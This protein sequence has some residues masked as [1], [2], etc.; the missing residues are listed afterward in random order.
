M[1]QRI[2]KDDPN[3]RIE[4][5]VSFLYPNFMT[6]GWFTAASDD[7]INF[8]NNVAQYYDSIDEMETAPPQKRIIID[9]KIT[10]L[11]GQGN[12]ETTHCF[13]EALR[14][15]HVFHT[16]P[17]KNFKT[18]IETFKELPQNGEV[19]IKNIPFIEEKLGT[20]ISV[21]G[22][23]VYNSKF[24]HKYNQHCYLRFE[25]NHFDIVK[26]GDKEYKSKWNKMCPIEKF[27]EDA[28]LLIVYTGEKYYYTFDGTTHNKSKIEYKKGKRVKLNLKGYVKGSLNKLVKLFKIDDSKKFKEQMEEAFINLKREYDEIKEVSKGDINPY[29]YYNHSSMIKHLIFKYAGRTHINE[30][31]EPIDW[32]EH[33]IIK[34][35]S[36]GGL[37]DIYSDTE[38]Y[39]IGYGYDGVCAYASILNS[40]DFYVPIKRGTM[41]YL[42]PK[43]FDPSEKKE[44]LKYGIY[45]CKIH[46]PNK[47]GIYFIFNYKNYYTHF[48]IRLA[49]KQNLKIELI[50]SPNNLIYWNIK[51][52]PQAKKPAQAIQGDKVFNEYVYKFFDLK[53]HYKNSVIKDCLSGFWGRLCEAKQ[54]YKSFDTKDEEIV[55]E[56]DEVFN[57]PKEENDD[58]MVY[59]VFNKHNVYKTNYARI[60]PFITA[61]LRLDMYERIF[62]KYKNTHKFLRIATDG[63]IVDKPIE[64]FENTKKFLHNI[65]K[66]HEYHDFHTPNKPIVCPNKNGKLCDKCKKKQ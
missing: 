42:D 16:T 65:V 14:K 43:Y 22:D 53:K 57:E 23:E 56:D 62:E 64:E 1:N 50:D 35:T 3:I 6:T 36:K 45:H 19:S 48:D 47:Q 24:K 52:S 31:T 58:K 32:Y 40:W 66:E 44:S 41:K 13:Y 51:C 29:R 20:C 49:F 38:R 63:V 18:F 39:K 2:N 37:S 4:Y 10:N 59:T 46:N 34:D 61:K 21:I 27:K 11:A 33:V 60:K 55:L 5:Q 15:L 26:L 30:A 7:I 28:K 54:K 17:Y 8:M 12:N 9:V 25:N